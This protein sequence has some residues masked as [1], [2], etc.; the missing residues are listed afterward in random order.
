MMTV[1]EAYE[2]VV[3]HTKPAN[4]CFQR[5]VR[6]YMIEML[7][8]LKDGDHE[9]VNGATPINKLHLGHLTHH[10]D[11]HKFLLTER[12]KDAKEI[13]RRA[14]YGAMFLVSNEDITDRLYIK[15]DKACKREYERAM[16]C[17]VGAVWEA[18]ELIKLVSIGADK[19]TIQKYV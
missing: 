11:G 5:G 14:C 15:R 9:E 7:K 13:V 6:E 8:K 2:W 3:N 4:N 12:S 16:D 18:L 17:Q 19:K 1:S 10:C